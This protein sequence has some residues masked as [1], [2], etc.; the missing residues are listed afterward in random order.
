MKRLI[1]KE[2]QTNFIGA[3]NIENDDL[4]KNII[5]FFQNNSNL[6]FQ[7]VSAA[8]KNL[9]SKKRTDI[10]I[11]PDLLKEE[12][13]SLL[14][15]YINELHKCYL[16]YLEQWPFLKRMASKMDIGPF[17][18]GEY[19]PGGHFGN[20]HSER[21]SINTLH[22]LFAFMTY[23]NKVEEGGTTY[24]DNY[25]LEIQPKKGLT[26][27]WP[28]EWTHTHRGNKVIKGT[29]YMITGHLCFAEDETQT[30]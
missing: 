23:L 28:A 5:S 7:G 2:N 19:L 26:L 30:N 27:I 15:E 25:N 22:R 1:V 14:K 24:F 3:W 12:K 6:H 9:N 29:K 4:C 16:D 10:S 21:T 17:N 11:K 20:E 13:F 8:G 18:I